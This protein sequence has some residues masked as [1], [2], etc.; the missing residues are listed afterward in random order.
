MTDTILTPAAAAS[1]VHALFDRLC[2]LQVLTRLT[3]ANLPND[4]DSDVPMALLN[5]MQEMLSTDAAAAYRLGEAVAKMAAS[6]DHL[7]T[8]A[9]ATA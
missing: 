6:G 9:G 4:T 7:Q 8:V 3:L 5:G 1:R 2:M